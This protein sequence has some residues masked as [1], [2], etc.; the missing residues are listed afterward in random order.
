MKKVLLYILLLSGTYLQGQALTVQPVAFG[1]YRSTGGV[2]SWEESPISLLGYGVVGEIGQGS[3]NL[4]TEIVG[5]NFL[6]LRRLPDPLSSEHAGYSWVIHTTDSLKEFGTDLTTMK[7]S[8]KVKNLELLIGK[9]TR[10][11]GPGLHSLILSEKAPAYPQVSFDWDL[12]ERLHFKYFQ[13]ELFSGVLDSSRTQLFNGLLGSQR[14]YFDRFVAGHRLVWKISPKLEAAFNEFVIYGARGLE[15]MY[16]M[17][18]IL[19]L[20]AE[21]L[22]GDNDNV[23]M[24]LDWTWTPWTDM[25]L[26]GVW[27]IDEMEVSKIFTTPNRNW[28]G[29]QAGFDGRSLLLPTDRLV[30]E[31]TWTDHRIYRHRFRVNQFEH[32]GYPMGHWMGPHAQSFL[33]AY[34]FPVKKFQIVLNYDYVKRGELTD[35]MLL[36]Q[37][38]ETNTIFTAYK[39]FTGQ[40]ETRHH[41]SLS[42]FYPVRNKLFLE[43]GVDYLQWQNP[44]FNPYEPAPSEVGQIS[45]ASISLGFYYNFSLPG[46]P[47]TMMLGK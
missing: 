24:S 45:K 21:H 41:L 39:R 14:V 3:W 2:W 29:Y 42:V 28:W 16:S 47:L 30:L 20:S 8:Y 35:E 34:L 10:S 38:L 23:Q 31:G 46:Y 12:S 22:L 5:L 19:F 1:I 4:V 44:D 32:R 27:F 40:T 13:G 17:P 36:N 33:A 43:A 26:Y 11:W 18:F 7:L 15:F 37:Y 9:F 25:K 6:G